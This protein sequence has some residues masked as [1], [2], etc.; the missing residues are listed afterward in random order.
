M[1]AAAERL[2]SSVRAGVAQTPFDCAGRKSP[3]RSLWRPFAALGSV[4]NEQ[5]F[6]HVRSL[7]SCLLIDR[8]GRRN[9]DALLGDK[10]KRRA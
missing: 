8:L 7:L 9:R 6:D 10:P 4:I 2:E 3:A 1:E 5:I